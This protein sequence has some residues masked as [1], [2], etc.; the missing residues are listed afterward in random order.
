MEQILGS[1][2]PSGVKTLLAPPDQNP[3]SAQAQSTQDAWCDAHANWN[4]FLDV[5]CVQCGYS[6]WQQQVPFACVALR[7]ASRVLCGLGL[8][9]ILDPPLS[10]LLLSEW[11]WDPAGRETIQHTAAIS[12]RYPSGWG[13]LH[14]QM[15]TR[16][17]VR[18]RQGPLATNRHVVP[19][20]CRV[21]KGTGS[22][23]VVVC[24]AKYPGGKSWQW[25]L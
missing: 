5:A 2:P 11:R 13:A 1:G 14:H 21:R 19:H 20:E 12:V 15:H 22:Q 25:V 7:V 17:R 18:V 8:T 9:K 16:E 24:V 10:K 4:A 6:H 23:S 3:G